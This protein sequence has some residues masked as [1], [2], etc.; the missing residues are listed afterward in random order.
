[1]DVGEALCYECSATR[2][3][4]TYLIYIDANT[5]MEREIMQVVNAGD[6]IIAQ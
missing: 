3:A 1:M 5:G 4:E 6:G 2:G